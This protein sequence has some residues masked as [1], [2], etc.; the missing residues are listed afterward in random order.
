MTAEARGVPWMKWLSI[1]VL[2]TAG[3][4][5]LGLSLCG[6]VFLVGSLGPGGSSLAGVAPIAAGALVV[7]LIVLIVSMRQLVSVWREP[8]DAGQSQL[9]AAAKRA[10]VL[11]TIDFLVTGMWFF[12]P[13]VISLLR[14]RRWSRHAIV[15]VIAIK[16]L[17]A[18]GLAGGP[19]RAFG[20]YLAYGLLYLLPDAAVLVTLFSREV[21]DWFAEN[22][23]RRRES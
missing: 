1:F 4:V 12:L 19:Y 23:A 18:L 11:T 14:R 8:G 20:A 9:P 15:A 5:G 17:G 7:G 16:W 2:L 13:L 3:I 6:G 10:A 22:R 21:S